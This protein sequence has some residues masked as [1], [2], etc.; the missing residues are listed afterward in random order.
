MTQTQS[1]R[2]HA[3]PS[4]ALEGRQT[5]ISVNQGDI[6]DS[7]AMSKYAWSGVLPR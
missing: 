3:G 1:S 2:D 6:D 7:G 4:Y 5:D